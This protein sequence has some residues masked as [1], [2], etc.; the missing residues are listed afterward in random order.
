MWERGSLLF[1]LEVQNA[2]KSIMC[3]LE[4]LHAG[5][6]SAGG[7]VAVLYKSTCQEQRE[8]KRILLPGMSIVTAEL[9]RDSQYREGGC[10]QT[11][12]SHKGLKATLAP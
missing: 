11:A 4:S 10:L 7:N 8:N 9:L 12:P 5:S 6:R 1:P 3:V 2:D